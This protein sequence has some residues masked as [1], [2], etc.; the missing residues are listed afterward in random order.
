MNPLVS[1]IIPVYNVRDFLKSCI[2]SVLCQ[3][4]RNFELIL[5][6]DGSNDGSGDICD[7]YAN[8]DNR[9]KVIHTPNRGVQWARKEGL[10]N[11]TGKY[12]TFLDSDD[13][14]Q[15]DTLEK[16]ISYLENDV[17]LDFVKFPILVETEEGWRNDISVPNSFIHI[18]TREKIGENYLCGN[19]VI[20]GKVCGNIFRRE[21][22]KDVKIRTDMVFSED[23]Y[24]MNSIIKRCKS[25][26][27]SVEGAYQYVRREN[28]AVHT[29]MT[30][31][32]LLDLAISRFDCFKLSLELKMPYNIVSYNYSMALVSGVEAYVGN[33]HNLELKEILCLLGQNKMIGECSKPRIVFMTKV[34]SPLICAKLYRVVFRL[35]NY[36]IL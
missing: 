5:V 36:K 2:D 13:M 1:V 30:S 33:S 4:M 24:F 31:K 11:I 26:L 7:D 32:K 23:T 27:I 12:V 18:S 15:K 35:R 29:K 6:D 10:D 22:L 21:I 25:C 3:T 9:V 20:L 17:N 19:S 8:K 16:N 34:T 14:L 28:S